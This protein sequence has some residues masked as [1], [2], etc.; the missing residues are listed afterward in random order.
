[1]ERLTDKV[2]NYD[3]TARSKQSLIVEDGRSKGTLT[4]YCGK[5][6]TKLADFEDLE[7]QDFLIKLK[8]KVGDKLYQPTR[9]VV[10]IFI[11]NFVEISICN[12][13]FFHTSLVSGINMTGDV[14]PEGEIGKTVFLTQVE[15]EVALA[16]MKKKES[17]C[18]IELE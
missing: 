17:D 18:D 13:L 7:D 9:D 16:Q 5:I 15:A 10:S 1:M 11:V 12:N 2:R 6:L 3:G 4:D 14:F 8:C